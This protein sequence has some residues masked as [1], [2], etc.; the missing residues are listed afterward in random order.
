MVKITEQNMLRNWAA[1]DARKKRT[2]TDIERAGCGEAVRD[3]KQD[4]DVR[5]LVG[6]ERVEH[7]LQRSSAN[8]EEHQH[9]DDEELVVARQ[10]EVVQSRERGYGVCFL[11]DEEKDGRDR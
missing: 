8:T 7:R 9:V 2:P 10:N 5:R 6:L 1:H 3:D 11:S 4:V